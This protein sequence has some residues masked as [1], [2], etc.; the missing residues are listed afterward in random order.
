MP[1]IKLLE[2]NEDPLWEFAH[3]LLDFDAETGEL[4]W[5]HDWGSGKSHCRAGRVK[6]KKGRA[7]R[8]VGLDF[9]HYAEHRLIWFWVTGSWPPMIDHMD[10]N[11]VN[12]KLSN[13]RPATP[14]LNAENRRKARPDSTTG[15]MGVR[16]RGNRYEAR[17][18]VDGERIELGSYE[19][20]DE[21]SEVFVAA[22]RRLHEGCTI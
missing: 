7:T 14:K 10:G 2:F 1:R 19:T 12:N 20:S 17:I 8:I 15:I 18:G 9:K 4:I 21:A 3:M 6:R 13:L 5:V 22:K 11:P 16:R